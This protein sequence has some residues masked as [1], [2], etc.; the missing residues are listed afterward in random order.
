MK[1]VAPISLIICYN[2][3]GRYKEEHFM[4]Q[5]TILMQTAQVQK[6]ID[7]FDGYTDDKITSCHFEGKKGI[8]ATFTV[9]SELDAEAIAAHLKS[10]FKATPAGKVLYFSIQPDTFFKK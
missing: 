6:L 8:K 10:L 9:E 4:A 7:F 5:H 1:E 2:G 3:E